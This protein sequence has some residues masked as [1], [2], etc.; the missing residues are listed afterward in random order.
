MF[1]VMTAAVVDLMYFLVNYYIQ[2]N[3]FVICVVFDIIIVKKLLRYLPFCLL[4]MKSLLQTTNKQKTHDAKTQSVS[5]NAR[6]TTT[7]PSGRKTTPVSASSL[8]D[9]QDTDEKLKNLVQYLKITPD[10]ED[11][12]RSATTPNVVRSR[13]EHNETLEL[14]GLAS[15]RSHGTN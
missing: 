12:L 1:F 4:I 2:I 11:Q 7:T 15:T 14:D 10:L 3:I 5:T 8:L 13:R 6:R 9:E